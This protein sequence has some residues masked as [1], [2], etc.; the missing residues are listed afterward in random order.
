M[1]RCALGT[2]LFC[3]FLL[4]GC[5]AE[6]APPYLNYMAEFPPSLTAE[7]EEV[8]REVAVAWGLRR[9]ELP[10]VG[11]MSRPPEQVLERFSIWLFVDEE[12]EERGRVPVLS[13]GNVFLTRS[14]IAGYGGFGLAGPELERLAAELR[15]ALE[16]RL[17]LEFC[18]RGAAQEWGWCEARPVPR[19]L[20]RADR[21]PFR[22]S[23]GGEWE[24]LLRKALAGDPRSP[25]S[26]GYRIFSPTLR[27]HLRN[28]RD[29][30][31]ALFVSYDERA[32]ARGE[33]ALALSNAGPDGSLTLA[34]YDQGGMPPAEADALA[35]AAK[36]ELT[37]RFGLT[38]CRADPATGACDERHERLEAEREAWLSARG[39][40]RAEDV[41]A[42]LAERPESPHAAEARERL[43]RLRAMASP[44]PP[45]PP[46]K[47]APWRGR[48]PGETFADPLPGGGFGP[49]LVVVPGGAFRMGCASGVACRESET[50]VREVRIARPF[51]LAR[52]EITYAEYR[53][54]AKPERSV[55]A[56]WARRPAVH[57]AWAEA[58]AYAEWLSARTGE[59]YRLPSEAEWERAARAGLETAFFWG[60]EMDRERLA[61][62]RT[63]WTAT[64]GTVPPNRW[65][66]FDMAGN[67][68]EWT[69][70]C[71]QEDHLEA[72][73]DGSART[74]GDCGRRTVRGGSYRQAARWQ[75]SAA[76]AGKPADERYMDVG[77]RV[78]REL[79]DGG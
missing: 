41:E 62:S 20:Y 10:K 3:C 51:A 43:A 19:L 55:H 40:N 75:R 46:A 17:G 27:K 45:A 71:W 1:T 52:R 34:A 58:R 23:P 2:L 18:E 24:S 29:G 25:S 8:V 9:S 50:P 65:G 67:A 38:L 44:Q 6:S 47:P 77:F 32:S 33:H 56:S 22:R 63:S 36:R 16:S 37:E 53:R 70:D 48:Q 79:R 72:P 31:F 76:R 14:V 30:D 13:F 4:G 12:A 28:G 57:L 68:A 78:L 26:S 5:Q 39:T 59:R 49:E 61:H 7:A 74:D 60:D 66:L 73:P 69:A 42:F 15:D 35:R 54:F 64:V 21:D 11:P